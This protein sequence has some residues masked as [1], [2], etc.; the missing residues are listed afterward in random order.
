MGAGVGSLSRPFSLRFSVTSGIR[1]FPAEP[2]AARLR[3]YRVH[4]LTS[5]F[6]IDF[7]KGLEYGVF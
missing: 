1:T 2:L 5:T 7:H 4:T 6:L 3:V